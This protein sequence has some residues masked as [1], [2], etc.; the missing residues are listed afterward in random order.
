VKPEYVKRKNK[1]MVI[2]C[3]NCY[4]ILHHQERFCTRC[5]AES[6]E[7]IDVMKNGEPTLSQWSKA[8]IGLFVCF[9]VNFLLTGFFSI[10]MGLLYRHFHSEDIIG[11][12]ETGPLPVMLSAF[13]RG[14]SL[15][16]TGLASLIILSIVFYREWLD[17]YKHLKNTDF[18]FAF[19]TGGLL[20]FGLILLS[21]VSP[22]TDIPS[23]FLTYQQEKMLP[24]SIIVTILISYT[25]VDEFVFRRLLINGLNEMT[26]WPTFLT[27][28]A[29][30]VASSVFSLMIFFDLK[31]LVPSFIISL[32]MGIL[33]LK[34]NNII[35]NLAIRIILIAIVLL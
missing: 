9:F 28:I 26:I 19:T 22:F 30:S 34:N 29:E 3:K 35:A 8:K 18:R 25:I 24:V 7:V 11:G 1:V 20:L 23:Y 2:R 15:L 16:I 33:Y 6:Q 13:S 4:K 32:V 10:I 5:G 31:Y 27:I 21:K 14:Y 12:I 17:E